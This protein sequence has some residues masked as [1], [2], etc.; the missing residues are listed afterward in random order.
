MRS[1]DHSAHYYPD[2]HRAFYVYQC[3]S[4]KAT[5]AYPGLRVYR[6]VCTI[7][8]SQGDRQAI[9]SRRMY[10]GDVIVLAAVAVRLQTRR[11]LFAYRVIISGD[12][13]IHVLKI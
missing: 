5:T 10:P 3:V 6:S 12:M 9:C 1:G 4:F 7:Y 8:T 13:H 2:H 11:E